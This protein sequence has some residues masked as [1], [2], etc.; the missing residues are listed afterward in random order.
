MKKLMLI[1]LLS[2]LLEMVVSCFIPIDTNY[3]N[4]L[5]TLVA[6]LVI[7]PYFGTNG[8]LYYKIAFGMGLLYDI[9]CNNTL[10]LGAVTFTL[11]AFLNFSIYQILSNFIATSIMITGLMI[12]IYRLVSYLL[13]LLIG[14]LKWDVTLLIHS[15]TSSLLLNIIYF[16]MLYYI[17][18]FLAKKWKI[19]KFY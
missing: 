9:L 19:I 2:I 12:I 13:L 15:I 11:I 14:Y 1:P 3:W 17:V 10:F 5:F 4:T 7:G 16:V 6:I 18:R 8:K